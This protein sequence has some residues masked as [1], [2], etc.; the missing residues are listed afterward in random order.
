MQDIIRWTAT[1]TA[2]ALAAKKVSVTEV[3]QAHLDRAGECE[4]YLRALV[5]PFTEQALD[6]ARA[7]DAAARMTCPRF[8]ACL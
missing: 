3:T 4:P 5:E 6:Q 2:A 7:M 1:Q 8:G